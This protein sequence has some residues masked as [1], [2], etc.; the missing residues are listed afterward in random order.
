MNTNS[1]FT[2]EILSTGS[3]YLFKSAADA[4]DATFYYWVNSFPNA[5][6]DNYTGSITLTD[7]SAQYITISIGDK[8]RF[9]RAE[10]TRLNA[11]E[12]DGVGSVR[13]RCTADCNFTGNMASLIGFSESIPTYCFR[14]MFYQTKVIDASK[15]ELP[16]TTLST[17]CFGRM[18]QG[19][20]S[21]VKAPELKDVTT[22]TQ[23][24]QW[25]FINCS[26]LSYIKCM[27]K[28]LSANTFT[29]WV[30]NVA[31]TGTF[32]KDK[33]TEWNTGNSGIPTGWTVKNMNPQVQSLDFNDATAVYIKGNQKIVKIY[34][35][36]GTVLWEENT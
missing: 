23:C 24:Y 17:W 36:N 13:L 14:Y 22:A 6:R 7:T 27:Q 3:L 16:W 12:A 1:Y 20:T 19:C 28:T 26:N 18:F 2:I 34:G 32:I 33:D 29:N 9:Y 30:Q 10:T 31:S 11:S 15:L 5:A 8:V 35:Q 25:M 21:L 4:P